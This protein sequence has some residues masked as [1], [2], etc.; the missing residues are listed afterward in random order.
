MHAIECNRLASKRGKSSNNRISEFHRLK[1][2][3]TAETINYI[4]FS[5]DDG[6]RTAL[7]VIRPSTATY[8]N[9]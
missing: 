5:D 3:V 7:F 8:S 4:D 9:K 2:P 6:D 1:S